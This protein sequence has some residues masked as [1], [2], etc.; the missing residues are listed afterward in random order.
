MKLEAGSPTASKLYWVVATV[1]LLGGAGYFLYDWKVGYPAAN[2]AE[3]RK[4]LSLELTEDP[5]I[6]AEFSEEDFK[7]LKAE[8]P[9]GHPSLE[10]RPGGSPAYRYVG[11]YGMAI[12]EARNGSVVAFNWAGF[13]HSKAQI[14][15]QLYFAGLLLAAALF[16]A[17]KLARTLTLRVTLDDEG[18]TYAGMRI[19]YGDMTAFTGFSPKGWVDLNYRSGGATPKLR[20]DNQRVEKFVEI[21][22]TLSQKAGIENPLPARSADEEAEASSPP[23]DGPA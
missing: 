4:Q 20:L 2:I 15:T 16:V 14:E 1:V 11:R 13:K 3:A 6:T 18:M 17:Y 22:D 19:P 12:A 21:I 23:V 8:K 7:A 10:A 9:D 5:K